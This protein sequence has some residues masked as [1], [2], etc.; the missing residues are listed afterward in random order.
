[1]M[2]SKVGSCAWPKCKRT[3]KDWL[4]GKCYCPK[5]YDIAVAVQNNRPV[6]KVAMGASTIIN[7]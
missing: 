2:E 3:G 6:N 1:M 5:H 4:E 7:E